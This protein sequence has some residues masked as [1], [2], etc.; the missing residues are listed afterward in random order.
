MALRVGSVRRAAGADVMMVAFASALIAVVRSPRI[1][2]ACACCL[3]SAEGDACQ[4]LKTLRHVAVQLRRVAG[5]SLGDLRKSEFLGRCRALSPNYHRLA[6]TLRLQMM[7]SPNL[8]RS[9]AGV[10]V[11][12]GKLRHTHMAAV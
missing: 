6:G 11:D 8:S 5:A 9:Q 4:K 2:S 7:L 10:G 12:P 3:C 1:N